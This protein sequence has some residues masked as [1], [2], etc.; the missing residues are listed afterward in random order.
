MEGIKISGGEE[1]CEDVDCPQSPYKIEITNFGDI[2][3]KDQCEQEEIIM[4][5]GSVLECVWIVWMLGTI[6]LNMEMQNVI[7]RHLK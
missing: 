4:K 1:H 3:D 2:N 5:D 7:I 6:L